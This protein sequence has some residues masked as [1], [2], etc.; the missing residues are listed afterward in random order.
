M[1][2]RR[3]TDVAGDGTINARNNQVPLCNY[4]GKSSLILDFAIF[5]VFCDSFPVTVTLGVVT[6]SFLYRRNQVT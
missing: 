5:L 4:F 6:F 1:S 3:D 2:P